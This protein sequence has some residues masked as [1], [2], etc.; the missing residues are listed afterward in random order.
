[1]KKILVIAIIAL[2]AQLSYGQQ[3][4]EQLFN[5]FRT[6]SDITSVNMDT[7]ATKLALFKKSMGVEG[8]EIL[9]FNDCE[10]NVKER[11]DTAIKNLKD[12]AYETMIKSNKNNSRTRILVKIEEN[13]IR[14]LVI[15][16]TGD[17]Y[18]LIRLKGNMDPRHMGKFI[19]DHKDDGR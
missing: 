4:V 6:E 2:I 11:L 14:E 13:K 9:R 8:I 15:L 1:M 12:P 7:I 19:N 16:T 5:N 10:Q 18:A 3:K 17:D